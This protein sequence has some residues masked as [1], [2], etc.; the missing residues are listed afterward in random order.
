MSKSVSTNEYR[1]TFVLKTQEEVGD[2]KAWPM[3]VS[4]DQLAEIL[5]RVKDGK[6]TSGS[7]SASSYDPEL[8]STHS[9]FV[10]ILGDPAEKLVE[11]SNI[12]NTPFWTTTSISARGLC[13][14]GTSAGVILTKEPE[15][16]FSTAYQVAA[17]WE[18]PLFVRD[19]KDDELGIWARHVDEK[20]GVFW[21]DDE[22][23]WPSEL[24]KSDNHP[25]TYEPLTYRTGLN[26][27]CT[28]ID[29]GAAPLVYGVFGDVEDGFGPS[30]YAVTSEA[31]VNFLPTVAVVG[32]DNNP[33][34]PSNKLYLGVEFTV[35]W[36][37]QF[38]SSEYWL[39][40]RTDGF[41]VPVDV[42]PAGIT[43]SIKLSTSSITCPLYYSNHPQWGDV[44][45]TV[46][47][48]TNFVLEAKKWW[49]YAKDSPATPL[50]NKDTGAKL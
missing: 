20:G 18:T 50:W 9:I 33:F 15:T 10:K 37:R 28:I 8:E 14:I 30:F 34:N 41:G 40:T 13:A 35:A 12:V 25:A 19:I 3:Q 39:S 32:E 45:F 26:L 5:Y 2:G 6:M 44:S 22:Y 24:L 1:C 17:K 36:F 16:R 23:G 46:G 49:P 27:H 21:K 48:A 31:S 47:S 7:F 4:L 11:V 29:A 42:V 43:F 38:A